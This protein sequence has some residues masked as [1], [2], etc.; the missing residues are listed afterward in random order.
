M[1]C[2]V[3]QMR[4]ARP[5]RCPTDLVVAVAEEDE[6]VPSVRTISSRRI[7]TAQIRSISTHNRSEAA[8]VGLGAIRPRQTFPRPPVGR[9]DDIRDS[10]I[11]IIRGMRRVMP[12]RRISAILRPRP[13]EEAGAGDNSSALN[14]NNNSTVNN[15]MNNTSPPLAVRPRQQGG[16][17]VVVEVQHNNTVVNVM[18]CAL[19][20]SGLLFGVLL[21]DRL[22]VRFECVCFLCAVGVLG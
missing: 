19:F 2:V 1:I 22:A 11:A 6:V 7:N 21:S 13:A 17:V 10:T 4:A 5:P 14:N 16:V 15:N 12:I 18:A 20:F 8:A 3:V 9:P